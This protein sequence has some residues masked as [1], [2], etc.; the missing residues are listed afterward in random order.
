VSILILHMCAYSNLPD[1]LCGLSARTYKN[2]R[3]VIYAQ[4]R[5]RVAEWR[6][7][8]TSLDFGSGGQPN[9]TV[10]SRLEEQ[11]PGHIYTFDRHY[12]EWRLLGFYAVWVVGTTCAT[13]RNIPEDAILHSHCR[14]NVKSYRRSLC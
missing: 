5:R 8:S 3:S 13:R 14:E 4:S 12:E 2:K 6:H 11:Y 9:G 10:S 7:N 1:P